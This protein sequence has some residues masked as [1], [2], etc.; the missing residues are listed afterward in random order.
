M[1]KFFTLTLI[2]L[3]TCQVYASPQE[4]D[5]VYRRAE[6][7]PVPSVGND[8]LIN[9]IESKIHSPSNLFAKERVFLYFVVRRDGTITDLKVL[10]GKN[11]DCNREALRVA[12][13][14]P[15]WIPGQINGKN[16]SVGCVLPILF[17]PNKK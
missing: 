15:A 1:K 6:V 8:S 9:F 17:L 3:W 5:S 11:E 7:V 13:T 14:M 10:S 4:K 2:M 12:E 16:V